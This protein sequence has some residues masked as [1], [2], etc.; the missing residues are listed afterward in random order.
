MV[1]VVLQA[2]HTKPAGSVAKMTEELYSLWGDSV[3][4]VVLRKT[5]LNNRLLCGEN[6]VHVHGQLIGLA[7]RVTVWRTSNCLDFLKK[8]PDTFL[9]TEVVACRK[10][11]R[12]LDTEHTLVD[13]TADHQD[14]MRNTVVSRAA[15]D[16]LLDENEFQKKEEEDGKEAAEDLD[17]TREQP[18]TKKC[19]VDVMKLKCKD[20]IESKE[21]HQKSFQPQTRLKSLKLQHADDNITPKIR[22]KSRMARLGGAGKQ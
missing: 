11:E 3:E 2:A 17:N 21:N 9:G 18:L 22:E 4:L 10:V 1:D 12:D 5:G 6:K 15:E 8:W 16:T 19:T 20:L 13:Q 7:L 14:Y